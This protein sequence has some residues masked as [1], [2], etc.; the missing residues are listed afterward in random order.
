[1]RYHKN[2]L[3][4]LFLLCFLFQIVSCSKDGELLTAPGI[5]KVTVTNVSLQEALARYTAS[6][7]GILIGDT[8]SSGDRQTM[9][10]ERKSGSQRFLVK[11]ANTG[12][13]VIDTLILL[14]EK[15]IVLTI[16][17]LSTA[18]DALPVLYAGGLEEVGKDEK[19][20]SF[21]YTD[22]LLPDSIDL[23]MY[24]VRFDGTV[25]T[26]GTFEHMK[27]FQLADFHKVD[28]KHDLANATYYFDMK[29]PVTGA[30]LLGS[31]F[32]PAMG[33]GGLM[34]YN[35]FTASHFINDIVVYDLGGSYFHYS[36]TILAY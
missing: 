4:T 33:A 26:L 20:W 18:P 10:I 6:I 1:M 32:N 9:V 3:S 12:K 15:S 16:L 13:T 23:T 31:A 21:Y 14:P 29:D 25:D 36:T 28:Y 11:D 8:L 27:K 35:D 17:K 30:I 34:A 5:T 19:L 22:P 7:D 24:R 2:I